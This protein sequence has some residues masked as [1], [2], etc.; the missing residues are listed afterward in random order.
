VKSIF[1]PVLMV[2]LLLLSGCAEYRAKMAAEQEVEDDA[3]CHAYGAQQ[4][5]PAYVRCL[6]RLDAARASPAR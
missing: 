4:G 6:A 3:K 2:T 1:A 5:D